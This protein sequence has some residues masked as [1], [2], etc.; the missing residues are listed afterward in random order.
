MKKIYFSF[1]LVLFCFNA[2]SQVTVSGIVTDLKGMPI[3][4]ANIFIKDSYDG[5]SSDINGTFS[6]ITEEKGNKIIVI[7]F[8]GYKTQELNLILDKNLDKL[9]IKLKEEINK[10]EGVVISAGSFSAGE[11]TK[12]EVLKPLDIVTTAGSSA[13]IAGALNTLPGTQTV[14]EEGRL[15]VR[16]GS[17]A[18][19]KT[20]I[21][22]MQVLNA[23][24]S[25]IPNTPSRGRFAPFMFKGTS[26]STGG[27]SAEYGQALS[28]ALILNSKDLPRI[29]RAD[30][31]IMSV[32]VDA[33]ITRVWDASSFSGKVRYTNISP[34]FNLVKQSLE[35]EKSPVAIDGNFAYRHKAGKNGM[36]KVYGNFNNSSLTTLLSEVDEPG[37]NT[38]YKLDNNYYYLNTSYRDILN[39]KWTV[40]SGL[41]FTYNQDNIGIDQDKVKENQNGL[42]AKVALGHD[43]NE[44]IEINMGAEVYHRNY[45]QSFDESATD[46]INKLNFDEQIVAGFIETDIY[47]SNNFVTRV[48]GR[49]EYNSLTQN[50]N[51]APR[52]SMSYKTGDKSQVALA[53]GQFQQTADNRFIKINQ[54]VESEKADHYILN[55]QWLTDKQTFRV[56]GYYKAY[57][58]LIK[59]DGSD[60]FN[61]STFTNNGTGYAQG[62]DIFWR[63]NKTFK[64]VDYWVSY[65]YL[66]TK[67]NYQD[68]PIEAVPTFASSHNFSVVY[69]QFF[70]SIKSQIGATY[71]FASG[72]PFHNPNETGFNAGKTKNYHDLSMNYTY[73]WKSNIL[74]HAYVTN[75]LG[76]KN[77]FGYEYGNQL[78]ESGQFN[79]KAIKPMAPRFFFIGVFITLSKDKTLNELPNL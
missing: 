23:Y 13:D 25:A 59:F 74:F 56:E 32:G 60:L 31:S 30:I 58:D 50:L 3:I 19:T 73:L 47:A 8:I 64:N 67:R 20:Y 70:S 42:H 35:L 22:G 7:T 45:E 79:R 4:G 28:S 2:L 71:S 39:D 41:A 54:E 65:S 1:L 75:V 37:N 46:S 44:Q 12:R 34:Y 14:G 18:E 62:I 48:G 51:L 17:G 57:K 21:D 43:L 77:V 63:D 6:F 61:P 40:N 38:R 78:N 72:R 16:G 15:F 26:F 36:F 49:L 69:K 24:N 9:S 55:Y 11:E 33:A 53:Y 66:D 52:L 76:R 27:Y 29:N 5:A 10:L 68:F